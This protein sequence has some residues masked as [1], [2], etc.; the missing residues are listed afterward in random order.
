MAK[1]EVIVKFLGDSSGFEKAAGQVAAK[2]GL[3]QN[4]LA[5]AGVGVAGV[6]IAVGAALFKVGE[7]F[8]NVY[9]HIRVSTG[10]TGAAL[11]GL[12]GDFKQVVKDVPTD[13]E[14]AG[15]AVAFVAQKMDATGK[16]GRGLSEQFLELSRI[17]KTDLQSN[18]QSATDAL[19]SFGV[20]A[21]DAP[22]TLD[23]LFRASQ[24]SGVS[25]ADLASRVSSSGTVFRALGFSLEQATTVV[26][27]LGKAGI[28]T[29]D[30][31]PALS[32]ALATAAKSGKSAQQVYQETI[33][34]IKTA[35]TDWDAAGKAVEV[36]GAKAGPKLATLIRE[37]KFSLDEFGD[38]VVDGSDT[39]R[40]AGKDTEDFAEKWTKIKNQVFVAI[41]PV[42]TK[43][44]N[45]IGG[46]ADKFSHLSP[47][48]QQ[49]IIIGVGLV[50]IIGGIGAAITVL[51]PV[52]AG[53]G[54][55]IGLLTSPITLVIAAVALAAILIVK[56]WD[57]IKEAVA[58]AA[59]WV[60]DHVGMMARVVLAFATGGMSEAALFIGRHWDDIVGFV[61]KMPGR[62]ASAAHGMWD[63]IKD[64]FRSAINFIIRGWNGLQFK[65]PSIDTHIP[66][67]GKIGGFTLGT[68]NIPLLA[69]G[70]VV[71]ARPGGTMVIAGEGGDDE[72]VVPLDGKHGFGETH[73]HFHTGQALATTSDIERFLID[74]VQR[75]FSGG[76]A[77]RLPNGAE[78]KPA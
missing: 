45:A 6:G 54:V 29:S 71:K 77:I 55:A 5:A 34:A 43:L 4:K 62:I 50:A 17:T 57:T 11:E 70:G 20:S 65:L 31:M 1:N 51:T 42:A 63:G 25:F 76:G 36:F 78:L 64:A 75:F 15:N 69:A 14:S 68:P 39:I 61:K 48:M 74:I 19:N 9:D 44:F 66:G 56:N 41:E 53:I 30:V 27:G 59:R 7:T 12:K 72:A 60:G 49:A 52:V 73:L 28:D 22:G 37:G 21:K 67:I 40:A 23:M 26:A 2:L 18:M 8:D 32:K 16:V 38:S 3:T 35:P 46:L 10:A 58:T 47:G 33:R 13:F 24:L